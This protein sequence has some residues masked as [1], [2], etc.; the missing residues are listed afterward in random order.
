MEQERKKMTDL[1]SLKEFEEKRVKNGIR[2]RAQLEVMSDDDL[3]WFIRDMHR[4]ETEENKRCY[5][6]G[7]RACLYALGY[8]DE[9]VNG[10]L[11]DLMCDEW[12]Y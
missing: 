5:I 1:L 12:E 6:K 2:R 4:A 11:Y 9:L 7:I 8:S 3:R 10:K